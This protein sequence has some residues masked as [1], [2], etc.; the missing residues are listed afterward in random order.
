MQK[1]NKGRKVALVAGLAL[2]VLSV[3]MVWTY[4]QEIQPWYA[5]W[6]DFEGLGKNEQGYVEYRH[7]QTGIVFVGLPTGKFLMGM[8]DAAIRRTLV[9][10]RPVPRGM[11]ISP[12]GMLHAE[13][14][15]HEV[16]LS[17]FLIGKYEVTQAEWA[18]VMGSN[19]SRYKGEDLP[20]DTVSWDNCQE[21]CGITGLRLPTEAQWEYAC[22]AGTKGPYSGTGKAEDM[23]W[24]LTMETVP[25]P[26]RIRSNVRPTREQRPVGQKEANGFGL[27]DTHGNVA[28]WC[29]DVYD[30]DF[31]TRPEA[32][33][34]NPVC[35]SA[36][37]IR[38]RRGGAW[39][40]HALAC[41]SA[42]RGG[43]PPGD[44]SPSL[45]LRLAAPYP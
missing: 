41:R 1:T 37:F 35:R 24:Y 39:N 8:G 17:S 13:Q 45:G 44:R 20:V 4:W 2:V 27:H 19:P 40:L 32:R 22:R 34:R 31:Y 5:F 23:G 21:F 14:P 16:E 28:E 6:Q 10:L 30:R 29:Q 38:V 25:R 26:S 7:R 3:G 9:G 36:S 12:D 42:T 18:R 15:A 11:G 43:L 33:A